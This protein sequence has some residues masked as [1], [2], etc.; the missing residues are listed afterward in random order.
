MIKEQVKIF[1]SNNSYITLEKDINDWLDS[2]DFEI[3]RIQTA[4]TGQYG[5]YIHVFIFYK[6]NQISVQAENL[7]NIS[8]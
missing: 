7:E 1:Y 3:I 4:V 5:S 2:G 6:T 8:E